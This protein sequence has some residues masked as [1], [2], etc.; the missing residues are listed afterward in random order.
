[1]TS[2]KQFN[3]R[4]PQSPHTTD[5]SMNKTD[6]V[7]ALTLWFVILIFPQTASEVFGG[8]AEPVVAIVAIALTY[9]IP[10]YLLVGTGAKLL[11]N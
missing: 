10:L 6:F 1:M 8:S 11:D 4:Y 5:N 2:S 3:P 9:F 7:Q